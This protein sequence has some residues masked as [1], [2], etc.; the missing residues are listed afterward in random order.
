MEYECALI[1]ESLNYENVVGSKNVCWFQ[2]LKMSTQSQSEILTH[3]E[4]V[5]GGRGWA[6]ERVR[7]VRNTGRQD[8]KQS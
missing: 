6:D 5:E 7:K 3:R 4:G 2:Y 8:E 1:V